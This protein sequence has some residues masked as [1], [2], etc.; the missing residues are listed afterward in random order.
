[1]PRKKYN[2]F[3]S[4]DI[5]NIQYHP[6][7]QGLRDKY[8]PD[9]ESTVQETGYFTTSDGIRLFTR[10]WFVQGVEKKGAVIAFHGAGGD[11]EYFVLLADQIVKDGF[12]V[13]IYD[14]Q[15]HGLSD[16]SRG[17]IK[18][19]STYVRQAIEFMNDVAKKN[20]DIPLFLLGESMGGTVVANV[21]AE[22]DISQIQSLAGI[23]LFAP[24]VKLRTTNKSIKDL[25]SFLGII[26]SYPFK[27]SRLTYDVRPVKERMLSDS[28]ET[29]D[30]LHFE[31][32]LT[33]LLHLDRISS[34]YLLQLYRALNQGN[35]KAPAQVK[36]PIIVF[37][38]ENDLTMDR[39]GVQNF[40]D[41]VPITDKKFIL[42]P[43]AP[44][45]MFTCSTFQ[46]FWNQ[47]RKWL[48]AHAMQNT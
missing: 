6:A 3:P 37:L 9:P 13:F 42:V 40:V 33:N 22:G 19:F 8:S 27:P 41:R 15:G 39:R 2:L 18:S 32:N 20:V 38:G 7:L 30:T 28:K 5:A 25:I 34:R 31:Y 36:W 14:Y 24:G 21:L 11:G 23:I 17:D 10:H 47:L 48:E 45:A 35:R 12:D 4:I 43:G 16:G 29:M 26:L 44:H 46:P 1:M